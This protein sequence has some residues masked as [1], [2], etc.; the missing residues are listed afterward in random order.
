MKIENWG[1]R[2]IIAPWS[3]VAP[4]NCHAMTAFDHTFLLQN[5]LVLWKWGYLQQK[6]RAQIYQD[7][8]KLKGF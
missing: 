2:P 7:L 3:G 8:T 1:G 5:P 4:K 6:N